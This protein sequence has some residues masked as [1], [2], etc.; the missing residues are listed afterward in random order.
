MGIK[1]FCQGKNMGQKEYSCSI[2]SNNE[3]GDN[4]FIVKW[5][6]VYAFIFL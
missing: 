4:L 5:T 2:T 1:V 3:I 6:Y